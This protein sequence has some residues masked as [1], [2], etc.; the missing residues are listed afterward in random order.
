M[1]FYFFLYNLDV[2]FIC[3]FFLPFALAGTSSMMVDKSGG[4]D[5]PS[6]F[7]ISLGSINFLLLRKMSVIGLTQSPFLL[8]VV[9]KVPLLR[10]FI[11]DKNWILLNIFFCIYLGYVSFQFFDMVNYI[12]WYLNVKPLLYLWDNFPLVMMVF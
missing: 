2:L 10:I 7:L 9:G 6:L 4:V 3:V 8:N 11:R 5:I 1:E 12:N